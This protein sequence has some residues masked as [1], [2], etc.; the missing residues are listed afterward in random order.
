M[1]D[2]EVIM[3]T[4]SKISVRIEFEVVIDHDDFLNEDYTTDYGKIANFC[5]SPEIF[6]KLKNG[7][8]EYSNTF[9]MA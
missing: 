4:K 9:K 3:I 2:E 1:Y 8:I 7:E 5:T 6:D